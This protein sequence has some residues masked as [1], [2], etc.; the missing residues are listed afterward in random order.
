VVNGQG[1]RLKKQII[2]NLLVNIEDPMKL[3]RNREYQMK[4]PCWWQV[5]FKSV[6]PFHLLN[7][8]TFW[9]VAV[10]AR[11]IGMLA[12]SALVAFILMPAQC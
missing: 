11:V 5:V 4:I 8:L 12:V 1:S 10:P 9:A 7:I 2:A 3:L 6:D